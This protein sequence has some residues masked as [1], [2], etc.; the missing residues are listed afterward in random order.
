MSRPPKTLLVKVIEEEI[1]RAELDLARAQGDL[2]TPP[3]ELEESEYLEHKPIN[4][5]PEYL[6]VVT[7]V[8]SRPHS[9]VSG[10]PVTLEQAREIA[11]K[12]GLKGIRLVQKGEDNAQSDY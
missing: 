9:S 1:R 8:W 3:R 2:P 11:R 5:G 10:R 4:S 6:E 7:S 12:Q